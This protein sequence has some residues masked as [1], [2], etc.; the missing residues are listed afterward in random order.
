MIR[1]AGGAGGDDKRFLQDIS[2]E[3]SVHSYGQGCPYH[4]G[5]KI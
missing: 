2:Y 4:K 5:F 1:G 3:G